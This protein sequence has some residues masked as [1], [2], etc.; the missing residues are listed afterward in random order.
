MDKGEISEA[1]CDID[2]SEVV[3]GGEVV[4]E[5]SVIEGAVVTTVDREGGGEGG[6][7]FSVRNSLDHNLGVAKA[8]FLHLE[9]TCESRRGMNIVL[10]SAIPPSTQCRKISESSSEG[11]VPRPRKGTLANDG[12]P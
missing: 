6:S 4:I 11:R 3:I 1:S 2:G 5:G 9:Q 7:R 12:E 8:A 10:S